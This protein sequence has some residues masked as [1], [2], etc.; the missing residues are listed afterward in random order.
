M[1]LLADEELPTEGGLVDDGLYGD[2]RDSVTTSDR[3][4]RRFEVEGTD[5]AGPAGAAASADVSELMNVVDLVSCVVDEY[6]IEL[7]SVTDDDIS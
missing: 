2:I 3:P 6:V 5:P 7:S 1:R 4:T